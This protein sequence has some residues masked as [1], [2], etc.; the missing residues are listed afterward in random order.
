MTSEKGAFE[1]I[2][3]Q[4]FFVSDKVFFLRLACIHVYEMKVFMAQTRGH[5][6]IAI[7]F[8]CRA[9]AIICPGHH[10]QAH[11]VKV[12]MA[13]AHGPE[14]MALHSEVRASAIICPRHQHQAYYVKVQTAR[15]HGP[16]Q[17]ALH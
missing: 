10:R 4:S 7:N 17:T 6:L 12:Q 13:R 2:A 8:S 16:E 15:A 1:H 9:S 14:Q 3:H 11:Y 5:Q